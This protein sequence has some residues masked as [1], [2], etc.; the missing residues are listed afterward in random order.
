MMD[1]DVTV[2]QCREDAL[3]C[4]ALAERRVRGR[5]EGAVLELRPV[6][7]VDLPQCRKVQ[8]PR[9]LHHVTGIHIEL[10]KQELEHVLG[11]VV[12]DL[13]S[14]RRPEPAPGQFPFECLQQ[15]FVAVLDVHVGIAGDPERVLFDDLHPGEQHRKE[16]GDE[17]FQGQEPDRLVVANPL[18]LHEPVDVVGHLHAGEVLAAVLG[19]LDGHGQVQAQTADEGE[20]V[21]RV[22]G[23]WSEYREHLLVE[24]LR[25]LGAVGVGQFG[26]G[27]DVDAL[28]GQPGPHGLEEHLGMAQGDLPGAVSDPAQLLAGREPVGR[29]DRQAHLVAPFQSG[30]A[31]HVELVEIGREDRQELGPFEQ[32]Q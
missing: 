6:D 31:H 17:F 2:A 3:R 1:Q 15:V 24:V 21:R 28:F 16:G 26:P 4:L 22:D 23:Q 9:H 5:H 7:A 27:D 8:Q 13:E 25:Q 18:Q 30:D 14:H 11:H 19:G 29:P 32:G 12:G 20:G 10:A